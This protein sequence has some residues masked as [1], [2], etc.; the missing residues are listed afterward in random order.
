MSDYEKNISMNK[1]APASFCPLPWS[2]ITIKT[3]GIHR[4]CCNSCLEPEKGILRDKQQKSSHVSL[5]K[6]KNIMNSDKIK[7]VRRTILEG[8]WPKECIVCKKEYGSRGVSENVNR[9]KSL[10]KKID[11]KNYPSYK[12]AKKLTKTDGS[13]S[14]KDFPI[15]NLDVRLGNLCNLKCITCGPRN[16]N[17]WYDDHLALYET[18][19]PSIKRNHDWSEESNFWNE[20]EKNI[21]TLREIYFAGG[22][23]LLIKA[24]YNFLQKCIN[25][26]ISKKL[27]IRYN[28]N[29]TYIPDKVKNLWANFKLIILCV[30]LDGLNEVNE[31][32]RYPSKWNQIEKNLNQLNQLQISLG[33]SIVP[34][35]SVLNIWHLPAFTEYI[36]KKNYRK[37]SDITPSFV[38][39]PSH[40]NI[41]ILEESFKE[42]ITN[43]FLNY[44]KKISVFDWQ[45][46]YG[47]SHLISWEEK[48]KNVC[49]IIDGQI[50]YMHK[51]KFSKEEL[52]ELRK[53]FI[54]F[55]DTLDKLRKTNWPEILPTL[56]KN[57]F[58]WRKLYKTLQNREN[59]K[60]GLN[61]KFY[62]KF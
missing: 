58:E 16:S 46:K 21:Y 61:Q 5:A 19:H 32:I 7:S 25:K 34:T 26:G 27:T 56:Y 29:I 18:P 45:S 39:E 60:K 15:S 2:R 28:S 57:T 6:W 47:D 41:N 52:T 50:E 31:L 43:H 38:H 24:H 9:Q 22:E 20:A 42:E 54:Y 1:G 10:A 44:K 11:S 4:I 53:S 3:D 40:L 13:I 17:N 23:P 12:K 51:I 62:L 48:I 8:K 37:V 55:M 14:V 33:L 36:L 59:F 35:V 30:S 49:K